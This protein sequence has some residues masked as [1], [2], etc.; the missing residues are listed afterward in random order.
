[1]TRL[2]RTSRLEYLK[3]YQLPQH[4]PNCRSGAVDFRFGDYYCKKCGYK[5]DSYRKDPVKIAFANHLIQVQN[6]AIFGAHAGNVKMDIR[7]V[8]KRTNTEEF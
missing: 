2:H 8:R 6:M 1:M 4:C 5:D 7:S 3:I